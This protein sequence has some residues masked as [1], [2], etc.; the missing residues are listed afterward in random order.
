M[1]SNMHMHEEAN[2]CSNGRECIR[3][4]SNGFFFE[5]NRCFKCLFQERIHSKSWQAINMVT[6]LKPHM[7]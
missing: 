3:L 1:L 7:W 4:A 2:R 6:Q 5:L